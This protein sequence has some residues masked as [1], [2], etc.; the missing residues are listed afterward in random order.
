MNQKLF[1]KPWPRIQFCA[2]GLLAS[3]VLLAASWPPSARADLAVSIDAPAGGALVNNLYFKGS[4]SGYDGTQL[5]LLYVVGNVRRDA[6][7]QWWQY[8]SW[9]PNPLGIGL[10]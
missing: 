1:I 4:V 7:G 10:H 2:S 9:G 8:P 6:D 5:P 3:T